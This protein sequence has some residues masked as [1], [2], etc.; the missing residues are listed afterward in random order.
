MEKIK[1]GVDGL[2]EILYGGIIKGRPYLLAGGPGAGKTILCMQFLM[3]GIKS[4]E[5]GLFIALEEQ[6][7]ELKED[8]ALFGWNT[9][10]VKI[11]DTIQD[12]SSGSWT[13]KTSGSIS[14]PEFTLSNLV[15][16]IK[17]KID[18][19]KPERLVIDSLTSIKMLY[20]SRVTAR[21]EMLGL[22]NS[23]SRLG[24]TTLLTSESSGPETLMEEYLASGVIKLIAVE[25]KGE[26]LNAVII[27]KMRG[28]KFDS[29][30]RPMKITD[31]GIIVYPDESVFS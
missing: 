30:I 22:I 10:R 27:Q 26:R 3:E 28:S 5:K 21:R 4:G 18:V 20:E 16:V 31:K 12:I 24:C 6:A 11:I 1:T 23:L 29:H 9:D 8:M 19:Y 14:K 25:E 17:E 15:N 7:D 2:D 13:L